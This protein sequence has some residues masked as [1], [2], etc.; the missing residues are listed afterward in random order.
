MSKQDS[1]KPNNFDYGDNPS[2]K[3]MAL[4]AI[5][6]GIRAEYRKKKKKMPQGEE[7]RS[8]AEQRF[9]SSIANGCDNYVGTASPLV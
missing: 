3:E 5:E 6:T 9:A 4:V 2:L 8:M 1:Q 7:L